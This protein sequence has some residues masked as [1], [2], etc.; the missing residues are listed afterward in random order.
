MKSLLFLCAAAGAAVCL[1]GVPSAT[2]RFVP[3]AAGQSPADYLESVRDAASAARGADP[4]VRVGAGGADVS[5]DFAKA[6]I[7][8]GESEEID[9]W[10]VADATPARV[11]LLRD[12]F[13]GAGGKAVRL[14]DAATG[15][16]LD[17]PC[18][19][20]PARLDGVLPSSLLVAGT[21]RAYELGTN[22]EIVWQ[23]TGCGNIH[24]VQRHGAYVYY[25]NGDLWRCRPPETR[26]ELVY[27]A[28]NRR[29]AAVLGFEVQPDGAV[30]LAVNS[31]DEVLE[32]A[33]ETGRPRV[34][35]AV[36]PRTAKGETPGA[37]AHLRMVH[38]TAKGTYLVCCAGA[39]CVREYDAAGRLVWEQPVPVMAFD[40]LRRANG[41]TL[42]SHITG[43]TEF[44][45]DHRAVW[46][47]A[48]EDL[49]DLKLACLCGIQE[50]PNGNLVMGTWANG[51]PNAARATACEV[52]REKK[53]VWAWRPSDDWNTMTAVR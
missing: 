17:P 49:P 15:R 12:L 11:K 43:V 30:V 5:D 46:T 10:R 42:V 27:R 26:A 51:Q 45:P 3:R 2:E 9:F 14:V 1:A 40:C 44:T 23:R 32:L 19:R 25:S 8:F 39:S 13:D 52:T 18:T 6:F 38:K 31:M 16:H 29:G 22:G 4:R 28:A 47:F 34:R 21:G 41:N 37:H 24:R 48:C 7:A 50:L 53:L 20:A 36:D 33:P 35:F